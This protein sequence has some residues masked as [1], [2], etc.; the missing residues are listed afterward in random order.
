MSSPNARVELYN[1]RCCRSQ[2]LNSNNMCPKLSKTIHK[3]S[4]NREDFCKDGTAFID[5]PNL[6][7]YLRNPNAQS[8]IRRPSQYE[9][10][11]ESCHKATARGVPNQAARQTTSD[12]LS[13]SSTNFSLCETAA[14]PGFGVQVGLL[15]VPALVLF[16]A[17][18]LRERFG[19]RASAARPSPYL[20]HHTS[21][22]RT[23]IEKH[24]FA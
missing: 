13:A 1:M 14:Q 5:G 2:F 10:M 7:A 19:S 6:V 23:R 20:Q 12:I 16:Q 18:H 8:S 4:S 9:D 11:Q 3:A 24:R 15:V 22:G 21:A 17:Q